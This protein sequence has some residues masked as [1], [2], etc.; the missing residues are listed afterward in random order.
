MIR[1]LRAGVLPLL[2]GALVG[3]AFARAI[4]A[5]D[6]LLA[7]AAAAVAGT[8]GGVALAT[9]RLPVVLRPLLT[10]A[11][12]AAGLALAVG[13]APDPRVV[14]DA[15]DTFL[16]VGLPVEGLDGMGLVA[17]AVVLPVSIVAGWASFDG[18]SLTTV[19]APVVGIVA[20]VPFVAPVGT[21]PLLGAAVVL[22][23]AIV[24]ALDL[25]SDVAA[26]PPLIGTHTEVR[27]SSAWWHP[28]V[29]VAPAAALALAVLL[30]PLPGAADL[31]QVVEPTTR[32]IDDPNPLSVASRWRSEADDADVAR[33]EVSGEVNPGRFRLSVLDSYEPTGWRQDA[34]FAVTGRTLVPDPVQPDDEDDPEL[35]DVHVERLPGLDPF[36][37]LP[38]AGTPHGVEDPNGV[39]Y[40][41]GPAVLHRSEG[42]RL[43]VSTAP[44]TAANAVPDEPVASSFPATLGSCPDSETVRLVADQLV[45]GTTTAQERLQRIED[46][47]LSRRIYDP[48]AP[49]GQTL[50][51]VERFL[52]QPF[53]RG[54]LE[55]FVTSYAVLARC[56]DVPA[57]VVVGLPSVAP[58]EP[59]TYVRS[60]VTAWVEVP[61][62][63]SGWVPLDP[64]P[65]PEEQELQA[66]TASSPPPPPEQEPPPSTPPP[67]DVDPVD[68]SSDGVPAA[69]L[70]AVGVVATAL[71]LLAVWTFVTPA[72]LRR[73]R[74]RIADPS[75][76]VAAAWTT[77]A[78]QLVDRGVPIEPHHTPSEVA[79]LAPGRVPVAVPRLLEGLAPLADEARYGPSTAGEDTAG[80]AWAYADEVL[81]RLPVTLAVRLAPLRHP[82][83]HWRRL[84]SGRGLERRREPW[85]ATLP[86]TAVL[87]ADDAPPDVPDVAV[88]ARIGDGATGTVYRGVEVGTGRA[89]AVKVF[90]YGPGDP[91]FDRPRFDWE[92]RIAREVSGLPHLPTVIGAGITPETARPYI[93]TSLH[94]RGTLL[95]RVRRGGPLT[96][97]EAVVLGADL[98]AALD[99][100]HQLGVLHSDVKPENVFAGDDGWVLGDLGSAWLRAAHGPAASLTPPYAA[101]EVWRGGVPTPA[102]D[103]F[104]VALTMVFAATG[105]VPTAGNPPDPRQVDEL[106]PDHPVVARALDPDP[107][108]RPRGA[109][110]MARRLR[111]DI[112]PS[113]TP[114]GVRSLSL[115]TPTVTHTQG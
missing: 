113:S 102:S 28:L 21:S 91:G 22:F 47:L 18:R 85:T 50:A 77:V 107:R 26:L 45:E 111:G 62:A 5:E 84:R 53:A 16:V 29:Q 93:V 115:P 55:V 64:L 34:R 41:A 7:T 78:E 73:R 44:R 2:A 23:A 110:E 36:R 19:A 112:R 15:V 9:P 106:F 8:V 79:R 87:S 69:A 31:R 82:L 99:A 98:A 61:F 33:I 32:R 43:T 76:A 38:T 114:L 40:A 86:D 52:G 104:S 1:L 49:G 3:A 63:D 88:D 66:Q 103:L 10:V 54:N 59:V 100:L 42:T 75:A 89:V 13:G 27:R 81:H 17:F 94:E 46:W 80:S 109:A 90:R 57:R 14:V 65:T 67:I 24:F 101:P 72:W 4:D 39:L 68:T 11:T 30:A 70:V 35:V 25:R 96:A 108:R 92:V 58:D 12:A 74:R 71:L 95:A 6:L 60:D 83:R 56:V 48:Q 37:S 51:G 20:T 97:P 105:Q